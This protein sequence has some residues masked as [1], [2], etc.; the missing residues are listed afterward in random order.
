MLINASKWLE[1]HPNFPP[2]SWKH[3][4]RIPRGR[5]PQS[6]ALGQPLPGFP[7]PTEAPGPIAQLTWEL[8]K[9]VYG[10]MDGHTNGIVTLTS[11]LPGSEC[12]P[13][14]VPTSGVLRVHGIGFPGVTQ[15][16]WPYRVYSRNHVWQLMALES[17]IQA[18]SK[19]KI[20]VFSESLNS[21]MAMCKGPCL[22]HLLT[23]MQVEQTAS[24]ST[25]SPRHSMGLPYMPIN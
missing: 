22:Y 25:T 5:R 1:L 3:A 10:Y 11:W 9:E 4:S 24:C 12:F 21:R 2:T 14:T 18:T 23:N 13:N 7:W 8:Y 20:Q 15:L 16:T 19:V 17:G 6:W